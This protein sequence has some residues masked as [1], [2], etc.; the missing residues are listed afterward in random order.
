M[1]RISEIF[2][3]IQGEGKLTGTPSV[4]VRTSG[5]NLRC[6]FCDT[7]YASWEPEGD[8][9]SVA[10]LVSQIRGYG[11][12]HVVLTGGEPA[13]F[14]EMG[15]LVGELKA[16]D[17]HITIETAG[18]V[19][20]DWACDLWSISPKMNNSDPIGLISDK[21]LKQHRDR[22]NSPEIVSKLITQ[23]DYQIKFVIGEK[24]DVEEVLRYL[25][26]LQD[27]Q[28]ENVM[29]MPKGITVDELDVTS[30]WLPDVCKDQGFSF[31]D[32]KHIHWFGN[33]RGT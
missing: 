26:L 17:H 22:R 14:D 29:L 25:E 20:R 31:C 1:I 4:F 30:S 6:S 33:T 9:H 13:I 19:H 3:S 10:K 23:S 11:C 27:W 7:R 16:Y 32:R 12:T 21:W 15:D 18:T 24:S 5:C 2:H 8:S 28:A